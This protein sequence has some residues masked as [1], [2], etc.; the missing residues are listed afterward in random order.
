[1]FHSAQKV[2]A[3]SNLAWNRI[4]SIRFIY[5]NL[6]N[7]AIHNTKTRF[8]R[9]PSYGSGR[10]R[11][12]VVSRALKYSAWLGLSFYRGQCHSYEHSMAS[13]EAPNGGITCFHACKFVVYGI[14]LPVQ[15]FLLNPS[16][17]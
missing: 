1:M 7:E 11:T 2:A 16:T 15:S 12:I 17:G 6:Q 5:S 14:I 4:R 13:S 3:L 10:R 8:I 9:S